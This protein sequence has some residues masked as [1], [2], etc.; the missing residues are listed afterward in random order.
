M[1]E[2]PGPSVAL[3]PGRTLQVVRVRH[4]DGG[5]LP[6]LVVQDVVE[7]ASSAAG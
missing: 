5:G 6:V 3:G 7:R 1:T 2:A 4:D